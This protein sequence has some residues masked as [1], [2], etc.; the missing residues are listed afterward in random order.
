MRQSGGNRK[1]REEKRREEKRRE[2]KRR[3]EKRRGVKLMI[4]L[5]YLLPNPHSLTINKNLPNL[6]NSI[7]AGLFKM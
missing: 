4:H 2:E 5:E 1:R 3:E 6:F 7:L